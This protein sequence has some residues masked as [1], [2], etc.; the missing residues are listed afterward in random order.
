MN[1][2][3]HSDNIDSGDNDIRDTDIIMVAPM[4]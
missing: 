1:G 2:I 4:H 3:S